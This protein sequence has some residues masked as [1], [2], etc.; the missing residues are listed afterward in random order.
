MYIHLQCCTRKEGDIESQDINRAAEQLQNENTH[1]WIISR[2]MFRRFQFQNYEVIILK[3]SLPTISLI[4]HT[5]TP[6]LHPKSKNWYNKPG[7]HNKVRLCEFLCT[8]LSFFQKS[9]HGK[10]TWES[11]RTAKSNFLCSVKIIL[12]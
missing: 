8:L 3:Y 12:L 1:I 9:K 5:K 2:N 4:E 7:E 6:L 10:K 11:C